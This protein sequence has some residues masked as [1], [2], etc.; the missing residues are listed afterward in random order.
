MIECSN[1]YTNS[2][3]LHIDLLEVKEL[4]VSLDSSQYTFQT[5]AFATSAYPK[6]FHFPRP[7]VASRI[8]ILPLRLSDNS[9]MQ[10]I[11][12]NPNASDIRLQLQLHGNTHGNY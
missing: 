10:Q 1:V 2:I 7:I 12:L 9:G 3:L 11:A 6:K 8:T 5:S 4:N